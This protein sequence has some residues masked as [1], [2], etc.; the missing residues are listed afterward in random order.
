MTITLLMNENLKSCVVCHIKGP[1]TNAFLL[2]GFHISLYTCNFCKFSFIFSSSLSIMF[3][4]VCKFLFS[5]VV[6]IISSSPI[7][8]DWRKYHKIHFFILF[9]FHLSQGFP[10]SNNNVHNRCRLKWKSYIYSKRIFKM[11]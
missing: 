6:S 8:F 3:N 4:R 11:C 7:K 10:F 5:F 9:H 1:R 2:W